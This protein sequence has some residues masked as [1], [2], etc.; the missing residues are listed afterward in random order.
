MIDFPIADLLDDSLCTLWLARDLQANGFVCPH[1]SSPERR[2][3]RPQGHCPASRCRACDGYSTRLTGPL[4]EKTRQRPATLV[5][6]RRGMA[7]GEATARLSRELG[8]SRQPLHTLRQR[9][10]AK[11]HDTAPSTMMAGPAFEADALYHNAEEKQHAPSRLR[12]SATP[13]GP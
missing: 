9:I 5:L 1:C 11:L 4:V 12:R 13:S 10:Q 7:K 6:L 8:V 2:M 3:F